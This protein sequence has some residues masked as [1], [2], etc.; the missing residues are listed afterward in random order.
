MGNT[1]EVPVAKKVARSPKHMTLRTEERHQRGELR[2]VAT[3]VTAVRVQ[4]VKGG[5][6]SGRKPSIGPSGKPPDH[7]SRP[8]AKR[9]VI[10]E[11]QVIEPRLNIL[12]R[13]AQSPDAQGEELQCLD[14]PVRSAFVVVGAPLSDFPGF[15]FVGRAFLH[16]GED[17]PVSLAFRKFRL[18]SFGRDTGEPKPMAVHRIVEFVFAGGAGKFSPPLVENAGKNDIAAKSNA[19]AARRT[20]CEVRRGVHFKSYL[21]GLLLYGKT[22]KS[23]HYVK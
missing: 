8:T 16:P 13:F 23:T 18:Q 1:P 20:S 2:H 7:H 14:V 15:A 10:V 3:M 19:R 12:T 6:G 4:S 11:I 9:N 17:V 22:A 21:C 5:S